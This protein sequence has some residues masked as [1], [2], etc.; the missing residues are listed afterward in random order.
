MET[1][2]STRRLLW[3][4]LVAM[5]VSGWPA[6]M[7][8]CCASHEAR[9]PCCE[10][11][12]PG[13]MC[14]MHEDAANADST[15]PCLEAACSHDRPLLFSR[16]AVEPAPPATFVVVDPLTSRVPDR[17]G[18]VRSASTPPLTPPPRV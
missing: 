11:M 10:G 2:R 18:P 1:F 16:P 7:A 14:G 15:V 5:L 17:D 12:A 6:A 4:P 9:M 13:A 8:D 3:L